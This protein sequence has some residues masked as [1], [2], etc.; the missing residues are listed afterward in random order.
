MKLIPSAYCDFYKI[1]HKDQYPVGTEE[2]YSNFTPRSNKLAPKVNGRPIDHVVVFGLQGF[3][4]S[5][6]IEEWNK[7]FFNLPKEE[8]IAD[9][10]KLMDS[11][12]GPGV[13]TSAHLAELHDL[14]YLPIHIKALPEGSVVP[15]GIPVFTI[16]NTLKDDFWLTN[17]LET[18]LSAG[19]WKPMTVASIAFEYRKILTKYA[20][21]TGSAL[22]FVLWQGHDFSMRGIGLYDAMTA[23]PGHLTSFLGTDT[24]PAISYLQEYYQG[25]KTYVGG[26]VPATEH[27]VMCAGGAVNE[28]ETFKRII[29]EVHPTGVVSVVSD[30]WDYWD[31]ITNG[32]KALKPYIMNRKPDALGLCKTVFRPDSG[33]PV[34]IICG[35]T[36]VEIND[37][38]GHAV[39]DSTYGFDVVKYEGKFYNFDL[40]CEYDRYDGHEFGHY[41]KL[42]DEVPEHVVKGSIEV[43]WEIFGGTVTFTGHKM[44][45]SHV[46]LIYGDSITLDR[47]ETILKKLAA[48]GFA[49]GNVVFGIG[50]YT[51]QY[52]TRDS[53]GF[54]MKSTNAVIN[55]VSTPIFKDPKTDNGTKKSAKGY[56][57]VHNDGTRWILEQDCVDDEGGEL[58]TVLLDG[59]MPNQTTL[60]EI[61]NRINIEVEKAT[62]G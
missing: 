35:L 30:T 25:N 45:D 49:S 13:V 19:L 28:L 3:I 50:S 4:K 2:I 23:Q 29:T 52:I 59:A 32:A 22:D 62:C 48:K 36:Y 33:D 51:Y 44:L 39:Y 9:Y 40:E 10:Q 38:E 55:G 53:F 47:A 18:A 16:K 8:A 57:K 41:I 46:G 60:E 26:S 11:T 7:S 43:L 14:G 27:S 34:K 61:R 58:Q 54:A 56:L 20:K 5:F 12:L 21:Q 37:L 17:F 42:L 6:L 1:S 15:M 31:L 24:I